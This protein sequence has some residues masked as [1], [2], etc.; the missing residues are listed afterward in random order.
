[1]N[2]EATFTL[3]KLRNLKD[4]T[5]VRGERML[6]TGVM[7]HKT[8]TIG[9][10]RATIPLEHRRIRHTIYVVKND[11][12]KEYEGILGI[13]FLL[14][15]KAKCDLDK[16][17]LRIGDEI[18]KLLPYTTVILKPRSETVVQAITDTQCVGVINSEEIMP[19]V[20]IGNCL[21]KPEEGTCPISMINTEEQMAIPMPL[22]SIE[23]ISETV[24]D[25]A[26]KPVLH[27][28]QREGKE[29]PLAR[30]EQ[31]KNLIRTEHLNKEEKKALERIC[32]E[33]CDIFYLEN[34]ALTCTTAISHEI[35]TRTDSAPVNVRIAFLRSTR[36]K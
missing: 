8:H 21:V 25:N 34:D 3:I 24:P 26:E 11:F 19:G 36:K 22:V 6:L 5:P 20:F 10:I 1:L 2:T 12:P 28:T 13:D 4:E 33:F 29:P 35:N 30:K 14:K 31:L 27:M 23:E 7:G 17:Q 32:E 15:Q 18:F 9:K 16:R